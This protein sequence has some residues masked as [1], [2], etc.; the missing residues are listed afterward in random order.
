[1]ETLKKIRP[2]ENIVK[3]IRPLVDKKDVPYLLTEIKNRSDSAILVVID[4]AQDIP[5][6][7]LGQ[8]SGRDSGYVFFQSELLVDPINSCMVPNHRIPTDEE[9]AKLERRR[10]TKAQLPVLKMKD[11]VRRW[12]NFPME[13]IV[14]IDRDESRTYW[15]RVL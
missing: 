9:L 1:M 8:I 2:G 13:S 15:R 11:P 4:H 5:E 7:V 12:H 6:M 14:A 10:I 3:Y